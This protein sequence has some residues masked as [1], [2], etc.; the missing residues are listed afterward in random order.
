MW[1]I[2]GVDVGGTFTDV[3]AIDQSS[4]VRVFK[5]PSTPENPIDAVTS[6]IDTLDG[7]IIELYHGTTVAT[8]HVLQQND[9]N[10]VFIT[11]QGFKDVIEIGRQN[12]LNIYDIIPT[13]SKSLVRRDHRVE[14]EERV[15][16]TGKIEKEVTV[17]ELDNLKEKIKFL[18]DHDKINGIAI[19]FLF[20]FLNPRNEILVES[21]LQS[22]GVPI[23]RSSAIVPEYR[24]Y[25]RFSTT[26]LDV[27]LK[28]VLETYTLN[29]RKSI[30]DSGI[31]KNLAIMKSSG[32]LTSTKSVL[33]KPVELLISGLAGGMLAAKH[34]SELTHTPNILSLDIGGTST[35]LG[36]IKNFN[37]Q[38]KDEIKIANTPAFIPVVDV[39]TIGAGG[40]S[41]VE[42]DGGFLKVGPESAGANPG[43]ISYNLGG[44][45]LTISDINLAYGILAENLGGGIVQLNKPLA[46]KAI[47][48]MANNLK[49]DVNSFVVGVRKIFH[50]NIVASLRQ[51]S[52]ERGENP[53]EF[54]LLGFGGAGPLHTAEL[55]DILGISNVLIPPFP[56]IWSAYGL[57]FGN[58]RYDI[59]KTNFEILDH[60]NDKT[61]EKNFSE[62]KQELIYQIEDDRIQ[63]DNV[64]FSE[65]IDVR[66][67]GQSYHLPIEWKQDKTLLKEDFFEEHRKLYGFVDRAE[68]VEI[69]AL[70]MSAVIE[71]ENVK[72]PNI[73]QK[74]WNESPGMRKVIGIGNVEIHDKEE[75]SI[76]SLYQGPLI[77]EQEDT[78]IWVP[79]KWKFRVDKLGFVRLTK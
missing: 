43:P 61:L 41:I 47:E 62:L 16:A 49:T 68:I 40:G 48:N 46:L 50:E 71:S 4:R 26:I 32:G 52:T 73:K 64:K 54:S 9:A 18:M 33:K 19:G 74:T 35:D 76:N 25:E 60:V 3:I 53:N 51:I 21:S 58:Y 24:E 10:L 56:G 44:D 7:D 15:L 20:S 59:K 42:L 22:L 36:Q 38:M 66:F 17:E 27:Y 37:Y 28:P 14:V 72:L 70:K 77:I 11:T 6:A 12:R 1:K 29:L 78:T 2:V 23:S 8:N 63:M 39:I 67:K 65:V 55:A 79:P 75:F 5:I 30:L 13:R 69:V 31:V 57:L 34:T 45:K